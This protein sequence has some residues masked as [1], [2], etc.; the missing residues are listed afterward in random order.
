MEVTQSP[1]SVHLSIHS[2]FWTYWPLA[3]CVGHYNDSHGIETEGKG[4]DVVGLTSIL[5]RGHF[6]SW[7]NYFTTVLHLAGCIVCKNCNCLWWVVGMVICLGWFA[8]LHVALQMPL[9]LTVSCSKNSRLVLPSW[10]L[11]FWYQLTQVVPDKIQRAMK[12]LCVC[13][14]VNHLTVCESLGP[15][16]SCLHFWKSVALLY[17]IARFFHLW[18]WLCLPTVRC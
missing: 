4:Q 2:I 3:L 5:D 14:E 7:L 18:Y 1:P 8:D 13:L 16:K 12:R 17:R 11:P 9:P 10:F 6:S 15:E